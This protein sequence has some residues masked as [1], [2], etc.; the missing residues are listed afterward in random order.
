[1][2][3]RIL[4]K[5]GVLLD[6][7][8]TLVEYARNYASFAADLAERFEISDPKSFLEI[9][10]QQIV[11]DGRVTFRE[12]IERSLQ[13]IGA[14]KPQDFDHLVQISVDQYADGISRLPH[15]SKLLELLEGLPKAIVSN[16]PSD[17]QRAAIASARLHDDFQS[18]LISGDADVAV[19]KPAAEIFRLACRRLELPPGE[20]VMI[21]DNQLADIEG[22]QSAGIEALHIDEIIS[23]L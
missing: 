7:D 22:A 21:G 13:V 20:V 1:M 10:H 16:G 12:S 18:I 2:L 19:R 17:M 11:Q 3:D 4:S 15:T 14:S 8:G 5:R 6:L 9:Y 23:C